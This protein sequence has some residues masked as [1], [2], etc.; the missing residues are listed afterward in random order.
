MR[1]RGSLED[2][3]KQARKI[4]AM[5]KK[6]GAADDFFFRTTFARYQSQVE[7]A[8]RLHGVL[9]QMELSGREY[10]DVVKNFNGVCDGANK[11]AR[12]LLEQ[13]AVMKEQQAAADAE[14]M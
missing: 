6:C 8:A 11:T 2:L 3:Q 7:V 1:G 9:V 5:A 13:L 4:L 10:G 12:L 14:E